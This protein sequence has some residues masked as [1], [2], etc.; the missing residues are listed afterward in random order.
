MR[1]LS[2]KQI[3]VFS[4]PSDDDVDDFAVFRQAVEVVKEQLQRSDTQLVMV[5]SALQLAKEGADVWH[6]ANALHELLCD[7]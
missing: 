1:D 5:V 6:V 3:D 2:L 4:V 7:G